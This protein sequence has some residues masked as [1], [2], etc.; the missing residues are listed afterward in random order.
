MN[1][2]TLAD[3][4]DQKGY[5]ADRDRT[6]LLKGGTIVSMD[7]AVGNLAEGDLLVEGGR[8]AAIG[9][10]LDADVPTIDAS[11]KIVIP[12]FCDP[13]IH[14]WQGNLPRII[15]NQFG[16]HHNLGMPQSLDAA[17]QNYSF[18]MHHTFA[19]LYRPED[20]YIGTLMSFLAAAN[21]GITTVCD[22]AHNSRT[23]E[24]SDASIQAML[25]SGLRG[26]HAYGRARTGKHAGQ[27]PGDARRIRER[28]FS[29]DD[30]L[31]TFRFFMRGDDPLE[32]MEEVLALRRE[33]DAWITFDSGLGKQPVVDLYRRKLLDG[34]ETINHGN[35][36]AADQMRAIIDHG[37]T[38]NVCPRI[39]SQFR[40]GDIPY[41][42]W[43][44]AGL[45]PGMSNDDPATYPINMFHEMR[46]LYAHQR[47]KVFREHTEGTG[48]L[49]DLATVAD[50]LEAATVCNAG[51]C[52]L[53]HK[54]GTLTP[55]KQA[56]IVLIDADN[57]HLFPTHNVFC[58]VV[59]GADVDFVE[60]VFVA[61][62]LVKW[63]GRLVDVDFEQLKQRLEQS[64]D[65]LFEA[66]K[67]PRATI[68]FLD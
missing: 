25:D 64:R 6:V 65:Y 38:V 58:T 8:I 54:V 55:G 47:A 35:Y 48:R 3:G 50:M 27:F 52:A 67:W 44:D 40:Y 16:D 60:A 66:A 2:K 51:C 32:E 63:K 5:N 30:Q 22:N 61:G 23:P 37:A 15:G 13:H 11:G 21:S 42:A 57:P 59:Q 46:A 34:R 33:L 49:A 62:R 19:P 7:P 31:H 24:H 53:A 1:G 14:A 56:D 28:Y 12:G 10:D 9:A 39:E 68:D 4:F 20:I 45:K 43:R 41:Q 17:T 26:V 36:L 29:S 18:V